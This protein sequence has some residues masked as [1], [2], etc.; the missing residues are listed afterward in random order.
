MLISRIKQPVYVAEN[1]PLRA[2]APQ[3]VELMPKHENFGFQRSTRSEQ[4]DQRVP[5]QAKI[6]HRSNYRPIRRRQPAALGLR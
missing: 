2:T 6:A 5:D 3:N 4:S 1:H